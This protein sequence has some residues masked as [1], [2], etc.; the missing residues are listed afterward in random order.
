M[1][2]VTQWNLVKVTW[3]W[4]TFCLLRGIRGSTVI[5]LAASHF[6]FK[7]TCCISPVR[8]LITCMVVLL[9]MVRSPKKIFFVKL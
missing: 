5:V 6:E 2:L 1:Y 9:V 7:E 3:D 8:E 4:T